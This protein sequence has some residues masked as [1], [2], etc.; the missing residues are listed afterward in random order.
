MPPPNVHCGSLF[1]DTKDG[2]ITWRM[3]HHSNHVHG[4][5]VRALVL[6]VQTPAPNQHCGPAPANVNV[7][8]TATVDAQVTAT[9]WH[10]ADGSQ[11]GPP[12]TMI[13]PG[14]TNWAFVFNNLA[15]GGY[16]VSVT[17]QL[18]GSNNGSTVMFTV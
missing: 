15:A 18:G 3:E 1:C 4:K 2:V 6:N 16:G 17:A 10:A 9:V 11:V 8:G 14:N 5:P 7:R 13:V 12:Q